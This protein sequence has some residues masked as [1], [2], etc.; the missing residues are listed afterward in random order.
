[1]LCIR[2]LQNENYKPEHESKR[3]SF[4]DEESDEN[5]QNMCCQCGE[6]VRVTSLLVAFIRDPSRSSQGDGPR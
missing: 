3:Q 1:M 2:C 5:L 6:E 4:D